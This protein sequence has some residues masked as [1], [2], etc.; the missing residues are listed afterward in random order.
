VT[1]SLAEL[2]ATSKRYGLLTVVARV[3]LAVRCGE[4]HIIAGENGAGKSTVLKILAGLVSPDE[5]HVRIGGKRV[6]RF[7]PRVAKAH[8]VALVAQHFSLLDGLTALENV[9]LSAPPHGP[10]GD[11]REGAARAKVEAILADLGASIDLGRKVAE[12]GVGERQR[13]EIARALFLD[14]KVLL[15]DEPTAVLSLGEAESLY[16]LLRSIADAG[17]AVVVVSHKLDEIRRFA[18]SVTVLRRGAVTL[19]ERLPRGEADEATM[20]RIERAILGEAAPMPERRS[21]GARFGNVVARVEGVPLGTS[22]KDSHFLDLSVRSGEIVGIAGVTGNGQEKLVRLLSG[23]ESADR[24]TVSL[25]A[26]VAVVHED[27]HREGLCLDVPLRDNVLL[28]EHARFSHYGVLDLAAMQTEASRR[29]DA[30]QVKG[31]ATT[32]DLDLPARALSGGNQQKVVCARAFAQVGRGASLL[33]LAHPTRGVDV[34]AARTIR[35]GIRAA[36]AAGAGIVLV[37]ADVAELRALSNRLF[38]FFRG[39]ARELPVDVSD[40]TL[41]HAMLGES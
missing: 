27:R 28:G 31:A 3:S 13:L 20:D 8:G 12:L 16:T 40:E 35:D 7:S 23:Q 21:E 15:L 10:L 36:S 4:V 34:R 29:L 33:V 32:L 37:S 9:V 22:V 25:P 17:R 14:A 19:D 18:D 41:G 26:E 6:M 38:V 39:R 2:E 30:A 11:F 5:G 1:A 24:G